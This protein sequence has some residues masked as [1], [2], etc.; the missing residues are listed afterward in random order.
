M[1]IKSQRKEE[2]YLILLKICE[3]GSTMTQYTLYPC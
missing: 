3:R 2:T 1:Q